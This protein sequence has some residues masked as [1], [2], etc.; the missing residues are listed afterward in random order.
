MQAVPPTDLDLAIIAS[1]AANV[2]HYPQASVQEAKRMKLVLQPL[3]SFSAA[4]LEPQ[5]RVQSPFHLM[6]RQF[7]LYLR[8]TR[9]KPSF[10]AAH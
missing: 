2:V 7:H 9:A 4:V 5:G 10:L 3:W 6:C 8:A 1:R